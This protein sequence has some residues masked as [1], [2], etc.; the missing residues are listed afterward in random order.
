M[1]TLPFHYTRPHTSPFG[2]FVNDTYR[3]WS[4]SQKKAHM[5]ATNRLLNTRYTSLDGHLE[6]VTAWSL[7]MAWDFVFRAGLEGWSR[8]ELRSRLEDVIPAVENMEPFDDFSAVFRGMKESRYIYGMSDLFVR[9]HM[10]VP[11]MLEEYQLTVSVAPPRLT[12]FAEHS[13]STSAR[14]ICSHSP[15]PCRS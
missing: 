15:S 8:H 6:R 1:R 11:R 14:L 9:L 2:Y 5:M 4:P 7:E 3:K 12:R 10:P 13:P